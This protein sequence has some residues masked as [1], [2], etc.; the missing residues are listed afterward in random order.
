MKMSIVS[1]QEKD[2]LI[3]LGLIPRPLGRFILTPNFQLL[4]SNTPLLAAG[5]FILMKIVSKLKQVLYFQ[6]SLPNNRSFANRWFRF[7]RI[8]LRNKIG[9]INGKQRGNFKGHPGQSACIG[10]ECFTCCF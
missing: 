2:H 3:S 5:Y 4:T 1:Y 7:K 9:F 8:P 10:L 6:T